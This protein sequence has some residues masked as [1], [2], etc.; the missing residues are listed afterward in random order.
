MMI[1]D[2]KQLIKLQH[3]RMDGTN[4]FTFKVYE[5]EMITKI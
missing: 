4:A 2:Y 5:S 3:I 1:K